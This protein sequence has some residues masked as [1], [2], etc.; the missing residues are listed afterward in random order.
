MNYHQFL[1]DKVRERNEKFNQLQES[2]IESDKEI[3]ETEALGIIKSKIPTFTIDEMVNFSKYVNDSDK[4]KESEE[5]L[6]ELLKE[7]LS[8]NDI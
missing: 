2:I 1:L 4:N 3:N 6:I 8:K 7:W 5:S